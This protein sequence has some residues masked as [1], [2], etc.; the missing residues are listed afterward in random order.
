[1]KLTDEE[2]DDDDDNDDNDDECY[3]E[4]LFIMHIALYIICT[5]VLQVY[6]CRIIS[7]ALENPSCT[8]F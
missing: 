6:T 1:M 7:V 8:F 5:N 2:Q 4:Q 3:I